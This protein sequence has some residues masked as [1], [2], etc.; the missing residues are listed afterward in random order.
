MLLCLNLLV[1]VWLL[2]QEV[3]GILRS[4]P[5]IEAMNRTERTP[6][7]KEKEK[8]RRAS[9]PIVSKDATHAQNAKERSAKPDD[10]IARLLLTFTNAQYDYTS[11]GETDTV[12]KRQATKFLRDSAE[13]ALTYLRVSQPDHYMIPTL[14]RAFDMA[15]AKCIGLSGG[16]KRPFEMSDEEY[17]RRTKRNQEK[18]EYRIGR[19]DCYR[20]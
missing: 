15:Q 6:A 1:F 16:R 9:L 10:H 20:P 13:N 14:Q 3:N 19:A 4:L 11:A 7:E 8:G 2:A 5:G 18:R 12:R 17:Y